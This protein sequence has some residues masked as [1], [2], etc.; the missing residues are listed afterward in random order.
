[1]GGPAPETR[2][3]RR[4]MVVRQLVNR[5]IRDCRVIESGTGAGYQTAILAHVGTRVYT[6]ERLP[7]LLVEAEE[8]FRRLGLRNI[9][10]RLGGGGGGWAGA[11]PAPRP[12]SVSIRE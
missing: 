11:P 3:V 6:V 8:R 10:T 9:A 2:R 1:M 7:D 12:G 4:R 5:G